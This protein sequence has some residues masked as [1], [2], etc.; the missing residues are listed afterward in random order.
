MDVM[1]RPEYAYKRHGTIAAHPA[2]AQPTRVLYCEQG[3][4]HHCPSVVPLAVCA[5]GSGTC[6]HWWPGTGNGSKLR[7]A[8]TRII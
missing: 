2:E 8:P 7:E 3:L 4:A 1:C 6:G 5:F